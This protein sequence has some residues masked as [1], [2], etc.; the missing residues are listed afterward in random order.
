MSTKINLWIERK[1]HKMTTDELMKQMYSI[2][3]TNES[4]TNSDDIPRSNEYVTIS[5]GKDI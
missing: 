1:L 4:G 5:S 2:G 3:N